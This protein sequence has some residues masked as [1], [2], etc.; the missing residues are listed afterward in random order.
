MNQL[1]NNQWLS[2]SADYNIDIDK[3]WFQILQFHIADFLQTSDVFILYLLW[4][5]DTQ[6]ILKEAS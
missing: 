6:R 2:L 4:T 5:L 3:L 1:P